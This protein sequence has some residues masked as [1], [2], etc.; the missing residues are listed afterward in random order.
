MPVIEIWLL[1]AFVT[2]YGASFGSRGP[3]ISALTARIFGRGPDL[4]LIMGA[5]FLGMGCGAAS[6]ATMGGL[7][8]DVR[9]ASSLKEALTFMFGPP[10]WAPDGTGNTTQSIKQAWLDRQ[11]AA[12]AEERPTLQAAE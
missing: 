2:L 5:I 1:W 8:R 4:G 11:A 7:I 6:G 10:G 12:Q 9:Y 3:V